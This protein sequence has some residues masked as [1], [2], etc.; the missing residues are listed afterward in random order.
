M[1]IT[2]SGNRYRIAVLGAG[3]GGL[4][5]AGHLSL[6]GHKVNLFNRGEERLWGV[7]SSGS[8]EITGEVEGFGKINMATTSIGDAIKGV[9]LIMVVVPANGHR[10]IAEQMAPFLVDDQIIVLH[11]GRTFGALEF[12]QVLVRQKVTANVI[13]AEAQ[14]FIY[15]SRATGPS[16]VHIFRIKNSI[17]VASIRAHLIPH[18]ITKLRQFYPQFVPGD[19]VFKTSLENIGS[20][21]HPA[22]CVLNAGWIEHDTDFQFYHEGVTP[23]VAKILEKIDDERVK[24]AEAIG[25]RAI[26]ARQW[27]YMAYSSAGNTL[28]EAMMK[29]VGYAGIL[30]PRSLR[31]R[32]IE[33]DVPFSLVPIASTGRMLNVPTPTI[34]SVI[35]LACG[36][37][38]TD[39]RENG[40]TVE[41]LGIAGMSVR[42][43]RLL[44]IGETVR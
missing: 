5:M 3:H 26:S 42:D 23:A 35:Q 8:I 14:T 25:I 21:F 18:V 30:A 20:V 33:E 4:A 17:P 32:Y 27:L 2:N 10:W 15:A 37:N 19:N 40:R 34:D 41:N 12:K 29:N 6:M 22:L 13:I 11:P 39:Y 28:F 44:A 24:V 36:L 38:E 43:L 31:V 16:Q 1:E 7:K 9:E